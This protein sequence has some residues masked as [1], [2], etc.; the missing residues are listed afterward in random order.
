ME[1]GVAISGRIGADVFGRVVADILREAR[2][3]ASHLTTSADADTS[4]TLIVN[5]Q[6]QDRRSSFTHVRRQS[7]RFTAADIRARMLDC[8]SG[9]LYFGGYLTMPGVTQDDL[10]EVFAVARARGVKTVLDIVVPGKGPHLAQFERLLPHTDVFLPNNDEAELIT[11]ASDPVKQAETFQRLGAGTTVITMGGK[12]SVLVQK[13]VKL[14]AATY[15]VPMVDASGGGDAFDAGY[16]YGL[17]A[18]HEARGLLCASPA[19]LSA[20]VASAPVG[21]PRPA[22][23]RGPSARSSCRRMRHERRAHLKVGKILGIEDEKPFQGAKCTFRQVSHL[24]FP[25]PSF[26]RGPIPVNPA[27]NH[28]KIAAKTITWQSSME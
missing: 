17:A 23:S 4:Q 26:V 19:P 18:R 1:V 9:V 21:T 13:D 16:I 6:G 12:G 3:D 28:V 8:T 2:V 24:R 5:V 20:R 11:G 10:A 25:P 14:R 22:C 15:Q 27:A 7:R